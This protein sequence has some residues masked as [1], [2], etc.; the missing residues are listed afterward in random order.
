MLSLY[1]L[2]NQGPEEKIIKVVRRD[3][4]ILFQKVLI[5][6]V[7]LILPLG[8]FAATIYW[9]TEIMISEA[10]NALI[11]LLTSA[12]YLFVWLFLFFMFID[13]YLDTWII[14]NE[15]IIDIDQRGFFSRMVAE[16]RLSRV[17]DVASEVKGIG[18]TIFKYGNVY[19]QTA[20]ET[21]RFNFEDVPNPEGIRD[22]IIKLAE[23]RKHKKE[24]EQKL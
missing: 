6:I 20:G 19:V 10:A 16:Q 18:S 22:L 5:F 3:L 8:F 15:R 7:L 24:A 2:P 4:I 14:T 17:Q 11:I 12:Y 1:G 9:Q 21:Q 23:F 13:Y